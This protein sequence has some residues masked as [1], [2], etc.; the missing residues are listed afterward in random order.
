MTGAS[1]LE[2]EAR[3]TLLDAVKTFGVH[4]PALI[5]VGAQAIYFRT[6]A[7]K[8]AVA[9]ATKDADFALDS[10]LLH[11]SPL[12]EQLLA[13]AGFAPDQSHNN[14][15]SW[16]SS[17][18]IP[19]DFL[20]PKAVA[21]GRRR[22]ANIPPHS[23]SVGRL[24]HGLDA[25]LVD[26]SL[27]HISSLD[28]EVDSVELKVAGETS[29]LVSKLIKVSERIESARFSAKDCHD[30]YRLLLATPTEYLTIRMHALLNE[31]ISGSCANQA[32]EILKSTF[33]T[34]PNS[35]GAQ[36]AASVEVG[37]GNPDLVSQSLW[38]LSN[39]LLAAL[40]QP[41]TRVKLGG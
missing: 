16:I 22:S 9:P 17:S 24:A 29:L 4:S 5:L 28:S 37:I 34:S 7:T 13:A 6:K 14:P 11:P 3:R 27:E 41:K 25:V 20:V 36:A 33:A 10:R 18:N 26:H 1:L 21:T 32:L 19:V 40:S 23:R 2:I 38:A 8:M 31:Q 35:F 15:G 39:D 12:L 30:I